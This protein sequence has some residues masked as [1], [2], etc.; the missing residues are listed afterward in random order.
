MLLAYKLAKSR[1][2]DVLSSWCSISY[3]VGS[4][5]PKSLLPNSF[6][7][8]GWLDIL[9]RT[10]E[11]EMQFNIVHQ[12]YSDPMAGLPLFQFSR[13]WICDA[14]EI[15]RLMKE[16]NLESGKAFEILCHELRLV[17]IPLD[18]HETA[19]KPKDN[20]PFQ[21][22]PPKP[23]DEPY[24]YDRKDPLRSHIMPAFLNTARGSVAWNVTD[25]ITDK[26]HPASFLVDR[27]D[28]SDRILALWNQ[29]ADD[30]DSSPAPDS[31][32]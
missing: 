20:I 7:E 14:Y 21:A 18:K 12:N 24:V 15:L 4:R 8:L 19:G 1:N 29:E 10:L 32:V 3:R 2:E 23:E 5:L 11:S 22:F 31:D 6:M 26:E 28:I 25:V 27:L 9:I 30:N 16:R 13:V 17:R